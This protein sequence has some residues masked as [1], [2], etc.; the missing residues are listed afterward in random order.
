MLGKITCLRAVGVVQH[1][2]APTSRDQFLQKTG[3]TMGRA[4][5]SNRLR[6]AWAPFEGCYRLQP[7]GAPS[8]CLCNQGGQR[9]RQKSHVI[10]VLE[11]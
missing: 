10:E 2:L 5:I 8:E 9:R 3:P 7:V 1:D 4:T 11:I 6:N